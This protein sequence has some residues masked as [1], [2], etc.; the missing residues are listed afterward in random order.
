MNE[1]MQSLLTEIKNLNA[2]IKRVEVLGDFV[3]EVASK[4]LQDKNIRLNKMIRNIETRLDDQC[5]EHEIHVC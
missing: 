5:K 2:L 4:K 3:N 1:C